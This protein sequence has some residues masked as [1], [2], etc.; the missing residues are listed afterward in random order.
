[1]VESADAV[2]LRG[3]WLSPRAGFAGGE[4]V[5]MLMGATEERRSR[6][7]GERYLARL[8][9]V[10]PERMPE[11]GTFA[12]TER[13]RVPRAY[14]VPAGLTSVV[15]LLAFHGVR[16]RRLD[17]RLRVRG[18]RFQVDSTRIAPREFQGVFEREAFGRWVPAEL[19]LPAGTLE[20]PMHQPLA[21][22][23]FHLL[24]PRAADGVVNWGLIEDAL[25]S[26]PGHYPISRRA[27]VDPNGGD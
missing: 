22:L 4:E 23:V 26:L 17:A 15:D 13:E 18:E 25:E 12:A 5:E 8:D 27:A 7:S 3:D 1:M 6:Y 14:Y 10:R 19:D 2:D 24:E 21:R 9:V 20:V 11:Y 16:T